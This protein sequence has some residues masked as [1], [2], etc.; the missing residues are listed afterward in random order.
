M[1]GNKQNNDL[2]KD[3]YQK[4]NLLKEKGDSDPVIRNIDDI[5]QYLG[6]GPWNIFIWI[7]SCLG[8][9]L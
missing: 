3:P 9:N 2:E 8:E 4:K 1:N 6:T 5:L 7:T